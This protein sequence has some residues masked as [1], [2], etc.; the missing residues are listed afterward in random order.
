MMKGRAPE[1][2]ASRAA[3]VRPSEV[4][5]IVSCLSMRSAF[6]DPEPILVDCQIG[7]RGQKERRCEAGCCSAMEEVAKDGNSRDL[8]ALD[9]GSVHGRME[10]GARQVAR[11]ASAASSSSRAAEP[12]PRRGY[13]RH[14]RPPSTSGAKSMF[15]RVAW[16]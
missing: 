4:S 2:G 12:W 16:L 1:R 3:T 10:S 6:P 5:E 13:L 8:R 9:K 15:P 11:S 14:H 7:V